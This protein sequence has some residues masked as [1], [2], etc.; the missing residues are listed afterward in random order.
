MKFVE[1]GNLMS[2]QLP[3][4][5][6]LR[7]F[8]AAARR[9]SVKDAAAELCVTA[10]AVSQGIRTLERHLGVRLFQRV[11]RG[12]LLTDAGREYLPPVRQAFHQIADATAKL[13][14]ARNDSSI[15][16]STTQF[17]ASAWLLPR[18]AAFHRRNPEIAID[19]VT[20]AVLANFLH[21]RVDLAIR[22]GLGHYPGLRSEKIVSMEVVPVAAVELVRREGTPHKAEELVSRLRLHG[23]NRGAWN[24]WFESQ[25]VFRAEPTLLLEAVRAGQL[26]AL[27]PSAL[28]DRDL[29]AGSVVRLG[30]EAMLEPFGYY[31]VYPRSSLDRPVVAAFRTWLMAA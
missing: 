5:N 26:H 23:E 13:T 20:G 22:H 24:L 16:V 1:L 10:G 30:A 3:P 14:A 28:V 29:A 2:R 4:L 18:L 17:F 27:L 21:D 9:Q 15:K 25:G 6:A 19:L 31:L 11:S 7:A 12:V 8:E